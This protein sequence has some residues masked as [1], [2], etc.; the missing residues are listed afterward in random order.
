MSAPLAPPSGD[1]RARI[2]WLDVARGLGIVL[3]VV[4]HAL[5]GLIDSPLGAGLGPIRQ[6]FFAI[7]TFHMPL[8]FVLA[9]LMVEPRL[10]RG[11]GGFARGLLPTLVWPYVLWSL[12]QS[13][14]IVLLGSLVNRPAG[15][16]WETVL[17]LPWRPVSQFW[18]LHALFCLHLAAAALL[19][20]IGR[21]GLLLLGLATRALAFVVPL[22]PILRLILINLQWYALG[23]WLG[24]AGLERL[25]VERPV[26]LRAA[27]LPAAAAVL[28]GLTLAAASASGAPLLA[29]A[30]SPQI[31]SMAWRLPSGAAALAGALAVIGLATWA[32]LA[33]GG[34]L[35]AL[36]RRT[37]PV[38]LLHVLFV[39]GARIV[40]IRAGLADPWLLL[41]VVVAAGLAGPLLV[42]RGARALGLTRA[43]GLG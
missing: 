36:G 7:Y 3:V 23:V 40:L 10:A 33:A 17:A 20:R 13:G 42:A 35:A 5:G 43:L 1:D 39:A 29:T 31:A 26:W 25:V 11:A 21:E 18:F 41:P 37:L 4:G 34:L 14:V 9:G 28:V 22:D 24:T 16:W 38:Y 12:V 30:S 15:P 2:A 19:P 32:P 27:V 6:A 8:F